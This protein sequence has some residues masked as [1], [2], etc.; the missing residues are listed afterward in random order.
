[1]RRRQREGGYQKLR[2]TKGPL[3]PN[4]QVIDQNEHS[5]SPMTFVEGK[6][7]GLLLTGIK[8]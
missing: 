1:M 5:G 4:S 3:T 7:T 2:G 6:A 8:S